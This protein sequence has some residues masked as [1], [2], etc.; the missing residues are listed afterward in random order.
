[1]LHA[2]PEHIESMTLG[3]EFRLAGGL[4]EGCVDR[5]LGLV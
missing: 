2:Q 1:V 3:G 4:S 5:T